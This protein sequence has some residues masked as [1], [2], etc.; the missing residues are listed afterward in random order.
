MLREQIIRE[1]NTLKQIITN[2]KDFKKIIIYEFCLN[3][4]A[5]DEEVIQSLQARGPRLEEVD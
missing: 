3:S 5:S 4:Q 1:W 2:Q